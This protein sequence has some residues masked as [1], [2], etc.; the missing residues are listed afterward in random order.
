[1]TPRRPAPRSARALRL[2]ACTALAVAAALPLAATAQEACKPLRLANPSVKLDEIY[3]MAEERAKAWKPDVVPAR[4]SNTILGPLKPD[5]SAEAWT[6]SF[7]SP[8][9][10]AHVSVNTFRG[11][12][13]C[14][15]QAGS[16]GR[17]PDLKPGFVLDGAKLYA[18][19][20]QHGEKAIADGYSV[21]IGTAARPSTR[22]ANWYLNYSKADG[23]SAPLVVILD[24]NSGKLESVQR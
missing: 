17:L 5:G 22:H 16:A 23:K 4:I 12:L 24:A 1:M 15:A 18:I 2:A 19:A 6:L 9:A 7:Y 11:Q 8:S 13:T 14:Y 10:N 3:R 20:R 21:M